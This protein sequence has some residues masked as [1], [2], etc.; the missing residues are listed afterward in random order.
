L[1]EKAIRYGANYQEHKNSAQQSLFGEESE[2]EMPEPEIPNCNPWGRLEE[3]NREKDVTGIYISGH[4]LDDFR[5]EIDHF[6]NCKIE[7]LQ[8]L[9]K[10]KG[11]EITF[12]G[13]ITSVQHKTDKNGKP[14]ARFTIQD[15]TGAVQLF[16]GTYGENKYMQFRNY[17]SENWYLYIKAKVQ[18]RFR[19]DTELEISVTHIELL[20]DV[21]DKMGKSISLF[22]NLSNITEEYINDLYKAITSYKGN[23][24]VKLIVEDNNENIKVSLPSVK[25]RVNLSKE[26][27]NTL[28]KSEISF[29]LN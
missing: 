14:Y 9:V 12:A 10:L 24:N 23:C 4:P 7:E 3:L 11:R 27:I 28:E 13:I 20:Q 26:F 6:C 2:V 19:S 17:L 5:F 29:S 1:L 18:N 15:Y 25:L 21:R 16:L 8:D 22:L